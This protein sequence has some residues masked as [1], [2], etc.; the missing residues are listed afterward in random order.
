M[1][2]VVPGGRATGTCFVCGAWANDNICARP[3]TT[4]AC[5]NARSPSSPTPARTTSPT[6]SRSFA[7]W[8]AGQLQ[9][10]ASDDPELDEIDR[11]AA[12]VDGPA[13][14]CCSR[15]SA[16]WPRDRDPGYRLHGV[17]AL[18][19]DGHAVSS[20][21][22]PTVVD[23][24]KTRSHLDLSKDLGNFVNKNRRCCL[25]P[26]HLTQFVKAAGR[27]PFLP[28]ACRVPFAKSWSD[29]R[30]PNRQLPRKDQPP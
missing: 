29:F 24:V 2:S 6:S 28:P 19:P 11:G 22:E 21:L 26:P 1:S 3:P 13:R 30:A 4:P 8:R 15:Q 17:A 18:A 20:D 7:G 5:S 14:S 9:L 16:S 12:T 10:D 25:A 23:S 27:L